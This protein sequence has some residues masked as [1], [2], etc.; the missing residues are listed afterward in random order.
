MF[1]IFMIMAVV[2]FSFLIFYSVTKIEPPEIY[3]QNALREHYKYQR[4]GDTKEAGS[5]ANKR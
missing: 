3:P 2:C 5:S 4:Y 1:G